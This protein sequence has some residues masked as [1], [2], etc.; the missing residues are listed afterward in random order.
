MP[1][2]TIEGR[3]YELITLDQLPDM[4]LGELEIL[5]D[6]GGLDIAALDE[7]AAVTAKLVIALVFLSMR[8]ANPDATVEDARRAKVSVVEALAAQIA[9]EDGAVPPTPREPSGHQHSKNA[10]AFVPGR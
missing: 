6:V 1:S 7:G 5:E 4:E 2:F 3:D 9:N 8:R 10:S